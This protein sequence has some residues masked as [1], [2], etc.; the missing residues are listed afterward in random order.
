MNAQKVLERFAKKQKLPIQEVHRRYLEVVEYLRHGAGDCPPEIDPLWH[1]MVLDTEFYA[2]WC[3]ENFGRFVHH[4][5]N[6][7]ICDAPRPDV[8]TCRGP[9]TG[10]NG[11]CKAV[12]VAV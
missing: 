10:C 7:E 1:E 5:P 9:D 4:R 8:G 3:M 6:A 12:Q 11:T 2:E